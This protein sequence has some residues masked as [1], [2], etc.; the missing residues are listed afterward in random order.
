MGRSRNGSTQVR[1]SR[2]RWPSVPSAARDVLAQH[3]DVGALGAFAD[4][5]ESPRARS[6]TQLQAP[7]F[8]GA[9]RAFHLDALARQLVQRPALALQGRIHGRYLLLDAT[10]RRQRRFDP[11]ACR[12][13]GPRCSSTT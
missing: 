5:V 7:D 10:K 4:Q 13:P 9:R 8:D 12:A 1:R 11:G 6:A 2:V 3:P